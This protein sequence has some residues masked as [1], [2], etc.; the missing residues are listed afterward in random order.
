MSRLLPV[1]SVAFPPML[2]QH[3]DL[4]DDLR[5]FAI[6]GLIEGKGDIALAG[7]FRLGDVAII[8][9][10]L[11]RM[12]LERVE[13]KDHVLR[14][15]RLAVMPFGIGAQAIGDGGKIGRMADA[16]RQQTVFGRDFVERGHHQRV[17]D[18]VDSG[19]QRALHAGNDHVEIVER[20][21]RDLAR[22]AAFRRFRIDVV[23]MRKAGRIFQR[24]RTA[25]G[26][27]ARLDPRQRLRLPGS[28]QA[29]RLR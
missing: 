25:T 29:R 15:H 12:L 2:R 11:R 3:V 19:S 6:A 20:A 9:R 21:E 4:A 22:A 17:V 24:Y 23:E 13:R 16:F 1:L 27:A 7:F 18:K 28:S 26:R 14:R 8:G 5:Q 10:H